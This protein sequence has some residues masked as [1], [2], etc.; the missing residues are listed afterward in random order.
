MVACGFQQLTVTGGTAQSLTVPTGAVFAQLR[1]ISAT[2]D[3]SIVMYGSQYGSTT[4]PTGGAV[5]TATGMALA[6]MDYFEIDGNTNI[7]NYKV[8]AASGTHY[9]C[10]TFFKQ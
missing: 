3:G 10:V 2:V 8:I 1:V 4:P 7:V 6:Y 9:L 5:G